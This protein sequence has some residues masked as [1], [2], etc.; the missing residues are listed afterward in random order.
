VTDRDQYVRYQQ[1]STVLAA[2]GAR[3]DL[4][5]GRINVRL[6]WS[7]AKSAIAAWHRDEPGD[8]RRVPRWR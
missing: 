1:D 7:T 6:P 8:R 3:L 5:V 2:I 4:Q